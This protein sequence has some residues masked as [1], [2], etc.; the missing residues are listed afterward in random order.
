[1][2]HVISK[3]ELMSHMLLFGISCIPLVPGIVLPICT[4]LSF[5]AFERRAEIT[6]SPI[7]LPS[8]AIII[9]MEVAKAQEATL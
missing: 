9:I 1:M 8:L 3:Y 5:D 6:F 7:T 4:C 2:S